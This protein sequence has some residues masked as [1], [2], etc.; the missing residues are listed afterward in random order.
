MEYR[1]ERRTLYLSNSGSISRWRRLCLRRENSDPA[2]GGAYT[3]PWAVISQHAGGQCR[4]SEV[5]GRRC[6]RPPGLLSPMPSRIGAKSM[7]RRGSHIVDDDRRTASPRRHC[8]NP[9]PAPPSTFLMPFPS[10]YVQPQARRRRLLISILFSSTGLGR[11]V[12]ARPSWEP[13]TPAISA[14]RLHVLGQVAVHADQRGA[15]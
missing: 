13:G 3:H 7:A 2:T 12:D 4:A 5:L 6:C 15:R 14:G 10:A 1:P 9:S 11:C 8:P